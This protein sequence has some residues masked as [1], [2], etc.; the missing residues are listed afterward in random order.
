MADRLSVSAATPDNTMSLEQWQRLERKLIWVYQ[1]TPNIP[2]GKSGNQGSLM[3]WWI[4]A[5]AVTFSEPS[6]TM[7]VEAGQ[8]V[9]LPDRVTMRVFDAGSKLLSIKFRLHWLD[10]RPLIALP[11]PVTAE[12]ADVA[13]LTVAGKMLLRQT[14]AVLGQANQ[15]IAERRGPVTAY[16]KLDQTLSAW[17]ATYI[18]A[19]GNLGFSPVPWGAFD[20]R[21]A[22]AASLIAQWNWRDG[23][24]VTDLA[25]RVG[26]SP[27]RLSHLFTDRFGVSL[28]RYTA[29]RR[30]S[31]A[32]YLLE[33]TDRPIKT[34]AYELGFAQPSH[35]TS[36]FSRIAGQSPAAYRQS[37]QMTDGTNRRA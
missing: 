12:P 37:A 28:M 34:I 13:D 17:L 10:G 18:R 31:Q 6:K 5:G 35:F 33:A 16:L 8:W 19:A 25:A 32:Q 11:G 24:R 9:F 15:H 7:R 21:L 14:V 23:F 27:S 29:L 4:Q 36:W 1:G 22:R 30:A 26:L 20:D 3:A 2:N